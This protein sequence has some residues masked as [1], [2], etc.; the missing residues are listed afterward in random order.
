MYLIVNTNNINKLFCPSEI[1]LLT[2]KLIKKNVID[3]NISIL[4]NFKL[5]PIKYGIKIANKILMK[6]QIIFVLSKV[7]NE[8]G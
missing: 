4:D 7:V 8:N 1:V 2:G 6:L 3:I 5:L